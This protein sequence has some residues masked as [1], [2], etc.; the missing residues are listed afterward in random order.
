MR[1]E[2][3]GQF[4]DDLLKTFVQILGGWDFVRQQVA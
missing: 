3:V 1:F 2:Q 4:N